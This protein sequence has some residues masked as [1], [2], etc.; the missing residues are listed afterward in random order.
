MSPLISSSPAD[1][2]PG[3]K[4]NVSFAVGAGLRSIEGGAGGVTGGG[5]GG[6]IWQLALARRAFK[7]AFCFLT[8]AARSFALECVLK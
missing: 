7:V 3:P 1:T 5:A 8:K 2:I 6:V 4:V